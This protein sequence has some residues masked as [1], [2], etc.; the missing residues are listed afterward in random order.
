MWLILLA[1]AVSA[2]VWVADLKASRVP[3]REEERSPVD[4]YPEMNTNSGGV[5]RL[6]DR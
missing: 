5:S 1:A 6:M 4:S 3:V 2:L